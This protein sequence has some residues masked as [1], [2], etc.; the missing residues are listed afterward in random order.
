M[1][2]TDVFVQMHIIKSTADDG[3]KV[4]VFWSDQYVLGQGL[5]RG[6]VGGLVG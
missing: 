1:F 3:W 2:H 6:S 4:K 5:G